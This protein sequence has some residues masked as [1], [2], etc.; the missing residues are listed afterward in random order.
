VRG[1]GDHTHVD[2]DVQL[3]AARGEEASALAREIDEAC[4]R[5]SSACA[6]GSKR[7]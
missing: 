2:W 3:V 1:R 4:A 6:R 5:R 7:P